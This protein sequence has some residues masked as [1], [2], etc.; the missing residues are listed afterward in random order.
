VKVLL[1]SRYAPLGASSRVRMYQFLPGLRSAGLEI[2]AAPLI[3][4]RQLSD[5]YA[6]GRYGVGALAGAYLRRLGPLLRSRRFDL[7]WLEYELFP[8]LPGLAEALLDRVG[9]P[10]VV[11]YDDAVFHRYDRHPRRVVRALLGGKIDGVMRRAAAVIAGSRYLADHARR[12]GARHVAEIPS[13]VDTGV[14]VPVARPPGD[15][16]VIG[17]IGSPTTA[18]YLRLV[19][20]VLAPFVEAGQ[21]RVVLVGVPPGLPGWAITNEAR[22][23]ALAREVADVQGFDVGI[24]PL[25]DEPWE[26]GKCGYKL[27]QY[28]ACG[29]P[30]VASAVGAN[31]DIVRH[32]IDG[33]LADSPG[34]WREALATILARS[35]RGASLGHEGR[36][37]VEGHYALQGVLPRLVEVLS[38]A[39]A[40]RTGRS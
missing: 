20:P 26:R 24:M 28:M 16:A 22:P 21:A 36:R 38:G 12:A 32:G 30:V 2:T 15:P 25:A 17:W 40:T 6:R 39:A 14:F 13:V 10:Y 34:Q 9:P 3:D 7:I 8:G 31:R 4:D 5:R 11:E 35:D 23:W 18:P 37:R 1:L 19:E 29:K 33:F 27:V